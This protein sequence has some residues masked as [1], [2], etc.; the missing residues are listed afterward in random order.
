MIDSS[1][2]ENPSIAPRT[3]MSEPCRP[4]PICSRNMPSSRAHE[5]RMTVIIP[6]LLGSGDFAACVADRTLIPVTFATE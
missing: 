3:P 2:V 5:A 1:K 6:G 4:L